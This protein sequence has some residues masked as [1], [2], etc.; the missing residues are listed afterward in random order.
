MVL[1][2]SCQNLCLA[3][4][5]PFELISI[6]IDVCINKS[7]VRFVIEKQSM[8]YLNIDLLYYQ[9]KSINSY[10]FNIHPVFLDILLLI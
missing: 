8:F 2:L 9:T 3:T 7:K 6:N 5:D 10:I 4:K 1:W